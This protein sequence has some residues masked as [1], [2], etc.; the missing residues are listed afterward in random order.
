[1]AK[2]RWRRVHRT[3]RATAGLRVCRDD[4]GVP[5]TAEVKA[6]AVVVIL[7]VKINILSDIKP[8]K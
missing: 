6:I 1:M 2:N 8:R 3:C 4:A 7:W 5:Q